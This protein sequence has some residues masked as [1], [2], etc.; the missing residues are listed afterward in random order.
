MP[1]VRFIKKLFSKGQKRPSMF[2]QALS[3]GFIDMFREMGYHIPDKNT[4]QV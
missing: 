1:L 2:S 3:E 4:D